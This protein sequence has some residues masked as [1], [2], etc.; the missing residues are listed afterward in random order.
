MDH[1]LGRLVDDAVAEVRHLAMELDDP[2]GG[3]TAEALLAVHAA[4]SLI[5]QRQ[6]DIIKHFEKA[7]S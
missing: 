7:V 2:G 3:D 1:E 4:L 5:A 6:D